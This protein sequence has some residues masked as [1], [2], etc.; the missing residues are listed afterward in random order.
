MKKMKNDRHFI[1]IDCTDKF[2]ITDPYKSLG[3]QFSECQQKQN[4]SFGH[5]EKIEKWPPV[6]KY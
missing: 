1:N 2:Q 3:L 5:Y 4:I 6:C